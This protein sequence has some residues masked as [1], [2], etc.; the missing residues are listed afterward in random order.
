MSRALEDYRTVQ[1]D[2]R[3]LVQMLTQINDEEKTHP[4]RVSGNTGTLAE[5][6]KWVEVKNVF[7]RRREA[8]KKQLAAKEEQRE[9]LYLNLSQT[10]LPM[11]SLADVID[12]LTLIEEKFALEGP[13]NAWDAL[14]AFTDHLDS[15][16]SRVL[17]LQGVKA[18]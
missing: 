16:E 4:A 2:A 10:P 5:Q 1:I 11:V 15:E 8:L 14:T 12:K 9:M 13:D 17:G 3:L 7:N 6:A 18:A